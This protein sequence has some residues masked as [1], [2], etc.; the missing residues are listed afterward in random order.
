M[1]AHYQQQSE[2]PTDTTPLVKQAVK[3]ALVD[4][5]IETLYTRLEDN[6]TAIIIRFDAVDKR[7]KSLEDAQL[8]A[9]GWLGAG[10]FVSGIVG[11]LLVAL[12]EYF[13]RK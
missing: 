5:D 12:V 1:S 4:R 7:L 11:G 3:A 2:K 6:Q 10:R 8:V 9:K 13:A